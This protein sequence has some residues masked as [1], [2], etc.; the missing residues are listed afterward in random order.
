MTNDPSGKQFGNIAVA[1]QST[2][3]PTSSNDTIT[4][5]GSGVTITTGP[6]AKTVTFE[7]SGPTLTGPVTS[8]GNATS[9][10]TSA[11]FFQTAGAD[12]TYALVGRAPFGGTINSATCST[13]SGTAT[14]AVKIGATACTGLSAVAVTSTPGTTAASAANTFVTGDII[15]ITISSN[16][17]AVDLMV[18]VNIT[19]SAA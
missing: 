17:T 2:V 5:V 6:A 4:L 13:T 18:C 8:V 12:G 11:T 16:S 15:K 14:A 7:A 19:G 1:G 3:I 10:K 9:V